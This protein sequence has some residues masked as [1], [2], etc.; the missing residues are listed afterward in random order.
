MI[1]CGVHG[2]RI[3]PEFKERDRLGFAFMANEISSE[4]RTETAARKIAEMMRQVKAAGG[5]IVFVAGP[6]VIHTGGHSGFL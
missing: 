3:Q 1:V 6:V 2:V 5:R 4:R